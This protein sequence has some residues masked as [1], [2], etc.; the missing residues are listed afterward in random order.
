VEVDQDIQ[1]IYLTALLRYLVGKKPASVISVSH[2]LEVAPRKFERFLGDWR[3]HISLRWC[4]MTLTRVL[5]TVR[6]CYSA[7]AHP[8]VIHNCGYDLH[9]LPVVKPNRLMIRD[10]VLSPGCR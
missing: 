2:C 7:P 8:S 1:K 5:Q 3:R 10:P 4:G 9:V 6:L